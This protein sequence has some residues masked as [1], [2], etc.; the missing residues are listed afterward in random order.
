MGESAKKDYFKRLDRV[1]YF[2]NDNISI[3]LTWCRTVNRHYWILIV[4]QKYCWSCLNNLRV[5]ADFTIADSIIK[6]FP[7]CTTLWSNQLHYCVH[8]LWRRIEVQVHVLLTQ[9]Y[10]LCLS[11]TILILFTKLTFKWFNEIFIWLHCLLIGNQT[12]L[13]IKQTRETLVKINR[14]HQVIKFNSF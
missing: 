13:D 5:L 4:T 10:S 9:R 2:D 3:S 7:L 8:S 11:P 14:L 1:F 12:P 6:M